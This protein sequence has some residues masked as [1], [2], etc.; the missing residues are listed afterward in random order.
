MNR[1]YFSKKTKLKVVTCLVCSLV[2][3]SFIPFLGHCST[4]T[5]NIHLNAFPDSF[6]FNNRVTATFDSLSDDGESITHYTN[7]EIGTFISFSY[8]R[9]S[10]TWFIPSWISNITEIN[11]YF[12]LPNGYGGNDTYTFRSGENISFNGFY[13]PL[14]SSVTLQPNIEADGYT[15]FNF[16]TY[17]GILSDSPSES[18]PFEDTRTFYLTSNPSSAQL[19]FTFSNSPAQLIFQELDIYSL[20]GINTSFITFSLPSSASTSYH[21]LQV[22]ELTSDWQDL[23]DIHRP[24]YDFSEDSSYELV[25]LDVADYFGPAV[26]YNKTLLRDFSY[27]ASSLVN[28]FTFI[29]AVFS[30][31]TSNYWIYRLLVL[32]VPFSVLVYV[33]KR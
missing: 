11:F 28:A 9:N 18:E 30:D 4:L 26:D 16:L 5:D 20:S 13:V 21:T 29:W 25:G 19:D 14:T 10:I 7:A 8:S 31:M 3:M 22:Q 2:L 32:S 12:D 17:Y 33:L 1:I 15:S 27:Y 6:I 23:Y 24:Y